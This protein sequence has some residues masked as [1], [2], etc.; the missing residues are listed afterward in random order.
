MAGVLVKW[1]VIL[2]TIECLSSD[3]KSRKQHLTVP[4]NRVQPTEEQIHGFR[5]EK[6]T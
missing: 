4:G 2:G 6:E 3:Q 1:V 5:K